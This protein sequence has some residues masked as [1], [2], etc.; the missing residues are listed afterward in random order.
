MGEITVVGGGLAGLVA[1]IECSEGG[2]RVRLLEASRTLGG[3]A[4]TLD[5]P[6]RANLG[7]HVIYADGASWA[8][9]RWRELL[10]PAPRGP[11]RGLRFYYEG[12]VRRTPPA[13]FLAVR[14]LRG[15]RAPHDVD[16]RTWASR[17]A[18][19]GA[20]E[21]LSRAAVVFAFDYDP[22]RLSA[23]FVKE[24][25]ARVLGFPPAA[26]YVVG[27][28]DSLVQAL[29]K[30][31]RELGVRVETGAPV[32]KLPSPPVIVATGLDA[33]RDLLG[34]GSL[35]AEGTRCAVLDVGLRRRQGWPRDPFA[36]TDLDGGGW[37][38][39]FSAPD[40]TL[41]P[42]GHELVQG[43]TGLA[44]AEPLEEGVRRLESVLDGAF[45]DWRGRETWRRRM[46]LKN[47]TG[48]VD[49]PGVTWRDRPAV[50]RGG[51]VFLAGD[52]VAA[53]GLLSEVAFASAS[54]AA[55]GA[56][57]SMYR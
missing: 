3:R 6:F 40:P 13:A 35:R 48:A 1:A 19:K 34:D 26:R 2:K 25:G 57:A 22:G 54:R 28:W 21:A 10:P 36:I 7:A 14:K 52:Q 39:R 46:E 29:A 50:D 47:L 4:R 43:H 18:G 8:W 9:L 15:H 42:P 30:R 16:F 17:I 23:Q 37:V 53:P 49:L 45:P 33:A 38:E 32:K 55:A 27:G 56:L 24:R 20:A 12:R 11:L 51:G 41:S 5:G 31:A 44:P